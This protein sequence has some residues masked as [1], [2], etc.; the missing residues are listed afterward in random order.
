MDTPAAPV[1]PLQP[2]PNPLLRDMLSLPS[3]PGHEAPLQSLWAREARKFASRVESDAYGNTWAVIEGAA[4]HRGPRVLIEAHA[5][6]IGLTIRHIS[7]DGFLHIAPLGGSDLEILRA[8]RVTIL[9]LNGP[10][11]GII[12]NTATHLRKNDDPGKKTKWPDLFVD[13][14][15]STRDEAL[16]AG[17]RPGCAAVLD[18]SPALFGDGLLLGRALD[19][20]VGGW[21]LL[22]VL[23]ELR[24][25]APLAAT[26]IAANCVHEEIGGP[27]ARMTAFRLNPDLAIVLDVTHAT[28]TPGI[29]QR[30]HGRVLLGRGPALTHSPANHPALTA[31]LESVAASLGLPLQ[32]ESASRFTGTDTDDIYPSR[33]G[34]PSA[35]VSVPLRYMHSPVECASMRDLDAAAALIAAFV[36]SLAPGERFRVQTGADPAAAAV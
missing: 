12:G 24:A 25:A 17:V 21:I 30:E 8:R 4:G 14:G 29:D 2:V 13:I 20:R 27:G 34:I 1:S 31:R 5:D 10:V 35:L 36:R 11:P 9:G 23:E 32:H 16:A 15:V 26:C 18:D 6:E 22:R 7:D 3:P 19:N 28:D 33:A